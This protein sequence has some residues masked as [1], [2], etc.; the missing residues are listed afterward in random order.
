MTHGSA[1]PNPIEVYQGVAQSIVSTL[2]NVNVS[3]LSAS[4][5]CVE[6]T[7]QKLINHNINVQT[8]LHAT[9]TGQTMDPGS[10]FQVDGPIPQEGAE[11]ALKSITDT[12]I[13]AAQGMDL[14]TVVTTP[15]GEMPAGHFIMM[16]MMDMVIHRWDLA[17]ATNQDNAID[18]SIAEIC[19]GVLGPEVVEGGR[20]M[21]A[22]GPEVVIPSTASAH[23]RLLGLLGRTP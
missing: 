19:L 21:G 11:A 2:G 23:N 15:F 22:F 14:S 18:S 1:R 6:W 17:S 7:V 10:M 5:P 9:L 8:F 13:S 3:Q 16:P 4:T 20:S 12:V